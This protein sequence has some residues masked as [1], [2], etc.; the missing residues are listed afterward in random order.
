MANKNFSEF[1]VKLEGIKFSEE[2][3]KRIEKG[4]QALVLQELAAYKP[5]PDDPD[6][7]GF[8]HHRRGGGVIVVPIKW[9]GYWLRIL[10]Q[11]EIE[12][13]GKVINMKAQ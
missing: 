4:M 7:P 13:I 2:A 1:Q 5:N 3:E 12:G 6:N 8:P 9:P 10:N 11:K